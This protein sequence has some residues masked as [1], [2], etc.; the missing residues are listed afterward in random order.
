MLLVSVCLPLMPSCKTYCLTW[1]FL[2][3]EWGI[4]SRLFQQSTATAPYRGRGISPHWQHSWP[5]TCSRSSNP[6]CAHAATTPRTCGISPDYSPEGLTLKLQLQYFV[7]L[8]QRTVSLEKILMLGRNEGQG[9]GDERGWD[10]WM[11]SGIPWTWVSA[12]SESWWWIRN[13]GVLQSMGLHTVGHNW[14]NEMNWLQ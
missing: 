5:W 4:S 1:V 8:M 11:A 14:T 10:G 9:E 13:P 2:T 7:H 12:S 3:L 6:F